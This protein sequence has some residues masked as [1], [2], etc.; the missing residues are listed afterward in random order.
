MMELMRVVRR[1]PTRDGVSGGG[2]EELGREVW[3]GGG[4]SAP[5]KLARMGGCRGEENG[6]RRG[7]YE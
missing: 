4:S 5:E 2:R 6:E 7:K 3:G 1:S